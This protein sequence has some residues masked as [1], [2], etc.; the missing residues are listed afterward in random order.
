MALVVFRKPPA[1]LSPSLCQ[2]TAC[3]EQSL[4]K[5]TTRHNLL[6]GRSSARTRNDISQ[7]SPLLHLISS[8]GK[9]PD[10]SQ[11]CLSF[12][13]PTINSQGSLGSITY[14]E[15]LL[16]KGFSLSHLLLAECE[17]QRKPLLLTNQNASSPLGD[18]FWWMH[19]MQ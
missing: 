17:K 5:C 2:P 7:N 8:S 18:L 1:C 14:A 6:Q 9:A 16:H 3:E 19:T 15:Q 11:P 13:A 4:T 12:P 10:S